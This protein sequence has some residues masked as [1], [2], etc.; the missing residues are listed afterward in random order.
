LFVDCSSIQ[1][2]LGVARG[3]NSHIDGSINARG[4]KSPAIQAIDFFGGNLAMESARGQFAG[5]MACRIFSAQAGHRSA[6]FSNITAPFSCM[7]T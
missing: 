3:W 6:A 7:T 2:R 1:G 5:L 4:A